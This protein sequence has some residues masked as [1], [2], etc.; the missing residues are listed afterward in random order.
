[1]K[2]GNYQVTASVDRHGFG[3]RVA[4]HIDVDANGNV[5]SCDGPT[6]EASAQIDAWE[7]GAWLTDGDL[8]VGAAPFHA[9]LRDV[10]FLAPLKRLGM[11]GASIDYDPDSIEPLGFRARCGDG[12]GHVVIDVL[13][14]VLGVVKVTATEVDQH[15]G[16]IVVGPDGFSTKA[17]ATLVERRY[18]RARWPGTWALHRRVDFEFGEEPVDVPGFP[19]PIADLSIPADS[20]AQGID[21]LHD[22]MFSR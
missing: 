18:T 9:S 4:P 21:K 14:A 22:R 1:M 8:R 10:A 16:V 5:V 20:I 13:G 17:T 12:R 3:V 19:R 11:V 15:E 7:W 6:F 2:I